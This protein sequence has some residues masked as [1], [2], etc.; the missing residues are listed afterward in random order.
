MKLKEG[1]RF[2][3]LG[4]DDTIV[5]R[6]VQLSAEKRALRK[7]LARYR[8]IAERSGFSGIEIERII[9]ATRKSVP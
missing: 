6:R 4:L 8:A 3:I 9:K 2:V 5:M 7:T 1:T